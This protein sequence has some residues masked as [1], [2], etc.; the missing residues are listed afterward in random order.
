MAKKC[1]DLLGLLIL[2][3]VGLGQQFCPSC[4]RVSAA[5]LPLEAAGPEHSGSFAHVCV[6]MES[7]LQH[8]NGASSLV[9]LGSR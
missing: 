2:G 4:Q 9:T 5:A 6:W 1:N 3:L 8:S 7:C